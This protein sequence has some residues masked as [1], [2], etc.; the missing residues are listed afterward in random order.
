[1]R[2]FSRRLS[3]KPVLC[4]ASVLFVAAVFG[5][6]PAML[7]AQAPAASGSGAG[8]ATFRAGTQE[9]LVDAVVSD[10][11]GNFQRDLTQHDFKI[12]EDGKEQKI[13]SFSLESAGVPGHSSKHFIAL[14]FENEQRPRL[15]EEV[16]QFVDRFASP[17]LYLAVFSRVNG[18][19][20]LQQDF[21]SD[22]GRVKA[23]LREM[24]VTPPMPKDNDSSEH[25]PLFDRIGSVATALAR[26]ADERR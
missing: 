18:E 1:M 19:M 17:D 12:W 16:M 7:V 11:K 2:I 22:A 15:R 14:V 24:Q 26:S 3:L 4:V 13:T 8:D 20:R 5:I 23:A 9:V 21:T 10:K 25:T 6:R